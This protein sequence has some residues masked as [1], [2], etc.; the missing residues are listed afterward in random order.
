MAHPEKR[1]A[2]IPTMFDA[3]L[4]P[5]AA[6]GQVTPP[7]H[8]MVADG[9]L[10]IAAGTDTT[11]NALG[12]ILFHVTQNPEIESKLVGELMK[13]MPNRE[14]MVDSATLEGEGFEYMRAVVKEGLRLAFGVP[15]RIIRKAPKDGAWF[16]GKFVPG[17]VSFWSRG[18][19]K[20]ANVQPDCPYFLD[21]LAECGP[22]YFPGTLYFRPRALAV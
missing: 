15:G 4:N 18:T 13:A 22:E 10:M 14:D 21:V 3:M 5:D 1:D 12:V 20:L 16:D 19:E 11:A 8:D 7:M 17:G 9:C 6:K 2:K